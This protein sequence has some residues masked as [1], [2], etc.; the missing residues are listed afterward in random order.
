M[1]EFP[2]LPSEKFHFWRNY[3]IL[4]LSSI[5]YLD[6]RLHDV[7][8]TDKKLTLVF[9]FLDQDLKK[10]LDS[11]RKEGLDL[12]TIKVSEMSES[13]VFSLPTVEWRRSLS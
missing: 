4:I 12:I 6:L 13:L 5:S 2:A 7:V 8:H 9:E 10:L 3:S 11:T 1:K